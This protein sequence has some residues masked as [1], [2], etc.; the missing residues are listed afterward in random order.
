MNL[1]LPFGLSERCRDCNS[2]VGHDA[3]WE[4]PDGRELALPLC[5]LCYGKLEGALIDS[6]ESQ[7]GNER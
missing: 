1:S 7:L 3:H 2:P 5:Q 4:D 6:R